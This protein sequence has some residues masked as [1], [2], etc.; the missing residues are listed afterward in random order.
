MERFVFITAIVVAVGY[1]IV[2]MVMSSVHVDIGDGVGQ[3]AIVQLAPG[4]LASHTYAATELEIKHAAAV[5]TITPEDRQDY[6]VEITN[7]GHAPMPTVT[8]EDD[9]LVIDG[10]L[11]G[12]IGDCSADGVDLRGYSTVAR[13]DLPHIIVHAPRALNAG[14][15]GAVFGEIAA[16]QS[17]DGSFSGCGETT[18]ADVSGALKVSLAGSGAVHA[19]AAQG[20]EANLSGSGQISAAAVTG[21]V[22]SNIS[23]SG[24][25]TV[26][27]LTGSL[28][29]N[30]S[31]SGDLH[32]Q[33]GSISTADINLVGSGGAVIGATIQ[34][35]KVSGLGSGDV[36]VTAAVHDVDAD[37]VGSGDVRVAS[38][39]GAVTRHS[40][41]SGTVIVGH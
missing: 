30:G 18:I 13:A 38:V 33:G 23:G 29:D 28:E 3:A 6:A 22:Q 12:R 27:S 10:N 2:A 5:V 32:V 8:L 39:S 4:N 40:V 26:A 25:I 7:P 19:G 14:F 24:T 15:S 36:E 1:A 9:H 11:R 41:G 17:V 20:L 34:N 16:A 35:L 37:L 21:Q 31:G